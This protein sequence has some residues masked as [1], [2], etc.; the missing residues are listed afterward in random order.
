MLT[1]ECI[2]QN[3]IKKIQI[4]P[5]KYFQ[6]NANYI[7]IL[8]KIILELQI[9]QNASNDTLKVLKT[10]TSAQ[11]LI[12]SFSPELG[13]IIELLRH[14]KI[15]K[16]DT[17]KVGTQLKLFL[18]FQNGLRAIFKPQWYSRTKKIEG[19][20][21][22]GKDRH[23]A[24]VVAFYLA[25]LLSLRRVPLALI[26]KLKLKEEIE[27][28]ATPELLS[29]IYQNG[30]NTC[31]YGVCHYCSPIDPVCGVKDLLEGTVL[32]WLPQNWKLAKYKHPWQRTY[33]RKYPA[34]WEVDINYCNKV[35]LLKTYSA[36]SSNRLLDLIDTAIFDFLIDNGDRHHY[37]LLKDSFKDPTILLIDNGK[38]LG[39]P[40]I[41]HIDI[42]APLY[43]CCIVRK[44][45]WD[46]L[47]L[48]SGGSLSYALKE[49]LA[50]ESSMADVLPIITDKHL[51][52]ID[53]RLLTVYAIVEY[54]LNKTQNSSVIA[55]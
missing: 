21:Y 1:V 4:L 22:Y 50:H 12:P 43:Q 2:Q 53:R 10:W 31:F 27:K 47:Q 9:H 7:S 34:L 16:A 15:I 8:D 54:C 41:D 52:A 42:L 5:S 19:P 20:V 51:N 30:D 3:I 18:T 33:T 24:E 55:K 49:L 46:R 37:E 25:L 6:Q 44:T 48:L 45:T 39:N 29:T 17:A 14:I 13:T 40:D 28:N 23:N 35:K 26:R 36:Q 38:S 11:Q 32:L